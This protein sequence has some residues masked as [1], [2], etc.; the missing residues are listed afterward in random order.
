[1]TV[2]NITLTES[3]TTFI[4]DMV[5][6]GRYHSSAEVISQALYLLEEKEKH[7]AHLCQLLDEGLESG[8][9]SESFDEIV[10]QTKAEL[11]V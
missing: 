11:N 2:M 6:T 8:E 5:N 9:C 10:A 4:A 3:L 7:L 1:M